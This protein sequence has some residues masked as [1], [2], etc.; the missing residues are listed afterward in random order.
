LNRNRSSFS[1]IPVFPLVGGFSGTYIDLATG[2]KAM[3]DANA[4]GSLPEWDLDE[5]YPGQES[6]E[7]E[8]DLKR[9]TEDADAFARA[10][11]GKLVGLDGAGWP[12]QSPPMSVSTRRSAGS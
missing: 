10:H 8:A 4:L 5:L 12:Q 3:S 2:E 6:P 7:L 1:P 9:A 11:E